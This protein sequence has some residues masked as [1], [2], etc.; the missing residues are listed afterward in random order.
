MSEDRAAPDILADRLKPRTWTVGELFDRV[1]ALEAALAAC[2]AEHTQAAALWEEAQSGLWR[3]V[4]RLTAE[5]D[6]ARA[7][8][9]RY[10]LLASVVTSQ[11]L[12]GVEVSGET[13]VRLL[14][15]QE[16]D[17]ARAENARLR[18]A[19]VRIM[20]SAHEAAL[21]AALRTPLAAEVFEDI[22]QE[23]L[24]ALDAAGRAP[25]EGG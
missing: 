8:V 14:A 25:E 23:V 10:A 15:E 20:A 2:R 3:E 11:R 19:L 1:R 16:R 7:E 17:E 22:S 13:A 6:A 18:G 9:E 5:R 21:G 12:A 24:A 4:D